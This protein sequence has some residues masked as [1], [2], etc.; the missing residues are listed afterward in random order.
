MR[1]TWVA[2]LRR[3]SNSMAAISRLDSP[4]PAS[5]AILV[6]VG[7]RLPHVSACS[8]ATSAAAPSES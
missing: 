5:P 7:V 6:P 2:I 1:E 3:G 8:L 4:A